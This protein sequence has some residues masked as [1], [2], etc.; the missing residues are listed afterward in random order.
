MRRPKRSRADHDIDPFEDSPFE[1][2][3]RQGRP[4]RKRRILRQEREQP[5]PT[6]IWRGAGGIFVGISAG[7]ALTAISASNSSGPDVSLPWAVAVCCAVFAFGC[8]LAHWDANRGRQVKHSEIVDAEIL[9]DIE[10]PE[11]ETF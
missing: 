4:S 2:Q 8:L 10:D 5:A 1:A 7:A 6:T 3:P 11:S 9:D